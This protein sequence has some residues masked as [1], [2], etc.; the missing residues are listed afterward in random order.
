GIRTVHHLLK[1]GSDAQQNAAKHSKVR[2]TFVP[3]KCARAVKVGDFVR[4][5]YNGVFPDGKKFDS[6]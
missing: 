3:E 1:V 5:H 2:K 6:R 4:Y